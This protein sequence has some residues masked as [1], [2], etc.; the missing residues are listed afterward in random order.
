MYVVKLL[1]L[2]LL[3]WCP[4]DNSYYTLFKQKVKNTEKFI[5]L[6]VIG[7]ILNYLA[8]PQNPSSSW[9]VHLDTDWKMNHLFYVYP[10]TFNLSL[11]P[12][13]TNLSPPETHLPP[14]SPIPL[15]PYRLPSTKPKSETVYK[16]P[17][18]LPKIPLNLPKSQTFP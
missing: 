5:F 6:R 4:L 2:S 1:S 12:I 18:F 14:K 7:G 13:S 15:S 11:T 17:H 16:T 9:V 3:S 8:A 10:L